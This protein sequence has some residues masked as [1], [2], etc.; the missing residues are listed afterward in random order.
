V[1]PSPPPPDSYQT[2]AAVRRGV[3]RD[4]QLWRLSVRTGGQFERDAV[5]AV[6]CAL[7]SWLS[8]REAP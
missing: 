1:R 2:L 5:E 7:F 3:M 4:P 8:P 6:A